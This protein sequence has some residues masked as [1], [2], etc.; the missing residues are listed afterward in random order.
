MNPDG[1]TSDVAISIKRFQLY[2]RALTYFGIFFLGWGFGHASAVGQESSTTYFTI[3]I[4]GILIF[5]G[6]R[7]RK[8]VEKIDSALRGDVTD[9]GRADNPQALAQQSIFSI[10][11]KI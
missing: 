8:H 4:G 3:V 7:L 9:H 6:R 2:D 11:S 10:I 5:C 1:M